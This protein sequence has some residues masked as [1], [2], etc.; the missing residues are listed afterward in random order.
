MKTQINIKEISED[1]FNNLELPILFE[2][3]LTDRVFAIISNGNQKYKF[4]WQS[5]ISKPKITNID[6]F[7]YAIGID[8]IFIIFD[9]LTGNKLLQLTL[10][11]FFY[12]IKIYKD[13][14]YVIS[15]LEILKIDIKKLLVIKEIA[16][17][18]YFESIELNDKLIQVKCVSGE[19]VKIE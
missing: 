3:K 6:K 11:Y 5:T 18:D 8:L 2:D 17:P 19:I 7:R 9:F 14:I 12:D 13:F 4:S 16:L 15:E 1:N 10:D